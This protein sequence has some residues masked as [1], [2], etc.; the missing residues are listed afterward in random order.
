MGWP[1]FGLKISSENYENL[2]NNWAK[3]LKEFIVRS[4][5]KEDSKIEKILDEIIK[6]DDKLLDHFDLVK[7]KFLTDKNTHPWVS[8]NSYHMRYEGQLKNGV[9]HGKGKEISRDCKDN[10]EGEF[11]EGLRNSKG[12]QTCFSTKYDDTYTKKK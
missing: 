4:K 11:K 12:K 3:Q 1:L 5:S 7:I 9:K 6:S 8:V 10:Y 2:S